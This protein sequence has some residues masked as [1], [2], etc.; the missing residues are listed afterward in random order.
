MN[1]R[2]RGQAGLDRFVEVAESYYPSLAVARRLAAEPQ[3][4]GAV[5]AFLGTATL[6]EAMR[7]HLLRQIDLPQRSEYRPAEWGQVNRLSSDRRRTKG[8]LLIAEGPLT[9]EAVDFETFM[10]EGPTA[11]FFTE[12]AT[13]ENLR[14]LDI[15]A[16]RGGTDHF[17]P[18]SGPRDPQVSIAAL[19][20]FMARRIEVLPSG[21]VRAQAVA[22]AQGFLRGAAAFKPPSSIDDHSNWYYNGRDN[23]RAVARYLQVTKGEPSAGLIEA[24]VRLAN[25]AEA[26][27]DDLTIV[28]A[29]GYNAYRLTDFAQ[30][31]GYPTR[32]RA[33]TGTALTFFSASEATPAQKMT[34][35]LE[36]IGN[37]PEAREP[38]DLYRIARQALAQGEWSPLKWS[39]LSERQAAEL[40]KSL[41]RY[42][43]LFA[44]SVA[45]LVG[46]FITDGAPDSTNSLEDASVNELYDYAPRALALQR[47]SPEEQLFATEPLMQQPPDVRLFQLRLELAQLVTMDATALD[48]IITQRWP[49]LV[50]A[51]PYRSKYSTKPGVA[52]AL[53]ALADWGALRG[54]ATQEAVTGFL[55]RGVAAGSIERGQLVAAL[56][57]SRATLSASRVRLDEAAGPR[58]QA[59]IDQAGAD[60]DRLVAALE[61]E[62]LA[63][64]PESERLLSLDA[65][66]A[67]VLSTLHRLENERSL[68][69]DEADRERTALV[70]TARHSDLLEIRPDL[71][72]GRDVF[73]ESATPT[74]FGPV[75]GIWPQAVP[76]ATARQALPEATH[77]L[78]LLRARVTIA[79]NQVLARDSKAAAT[80][81]IS[82][83]L[84][85]LNRTT[86]ARLAA[87]PA[88]EKLALYSSGR[89]LMDDFE[90]WVDGLAWGGD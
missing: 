54:G 82:E 77:Q 86:G 87:A 37:G 42:G 29:T 34:A 73:G 14:A 60:V 41:D 47:L 32:S 84:E 78:R 4:V 51:A 68:P 1:A 10:A 63:D 57:A 70:L 27:V 26:P 40:S 23:G 31:T 11:R 36:L 83:A 76:L 48:A 35:L 50:D 25:A 67:E 44:D 33:G 65:L 53:R 18:L 61:G 21:P 90:N 17:Y 7:A 9:G 2:T 69:L 58:A 43:Y 39:E 22:E 66:S 74:D 6:P 75:D 20:N 28:D 62:L 5:R 8:E 30:S 38:H 64:R 71:A 81:A 13:D 3:Y 89:V 80:K 56:T 19:L 55:Q 45:P 52:P 15:D 24:L 16:L 12:Y 85:L 59:L 79:S 88:E 72:A 49:L 46:L